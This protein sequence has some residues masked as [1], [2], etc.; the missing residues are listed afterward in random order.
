MVISQTTFDKLPEGQLRLVDNRI[1]AG[2]S[3]WA[4]QPH[5]VC[6]LHPKQTQPQHLEMLKALIELVNAARRSLVMEDV[7]AVAIVV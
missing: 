4:E 5:L 2:D 1:V 7:P 3:T 6:V